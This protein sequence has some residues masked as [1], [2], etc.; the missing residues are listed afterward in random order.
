MTMLAWIPRE[1]TSGIGCAAIL[2]VLLVLLVVHSFA[3]SIRRDRARMAALSRVGRSRNGRVIAAGWFN[4]PRLDFQLD[5]IPGELTFKSSGGDRSRWTKVHLNL[6]TSQRL[7]VT[8]QGFTKWL[9]SLFE[10]A[11][12]EVGDRAFDRN[13]WVESSDPGWARRVLSERVRRRFQGIR[14]DTA[15]FI[16]HDVT[17]AVGPAGITLKVSRLLADDWENLEWFLEMATL[18]LDEVRSQADV[19]GVTVEGVVISLDSACPVCG[20]GVTAGR[21]CS[22]CGTPHHFECWKYNDGCAIFACSSRRS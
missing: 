2:M 11:D 3:Q 19:A 7:R 8:P 1:D 13:F 9:K 14:Q 5:S 6:P 21:T 15:I 10:G 22:Q 18:I 12:I 4:D 16:A 17:L 20:H